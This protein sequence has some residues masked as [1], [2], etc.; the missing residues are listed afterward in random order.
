MPRL[1]RPLPSRRRAA[2]VIVGW[3]MLGGLAVGVAA[4]PR[5]AAKPA[6]VSPK[7]AAPVVL[8]SAVASVPAG[9]QSLPL[10]ALHPNF[11]DPA[12]EAMIVEGVKPAPLASLRGLIVPHHL[13]AA[14][15]IAR[16]YAA[17]PAGVTTVF[18]VGPNHRNEGGAQFTTAAA[19]WTT[20]AG[21]VSADEAQ[22]ARLA[23]D[24]G[25]ATS[26]EPFRDE[27]SVGVQ[28]Y[29]IRRFLPQAKIVP[30]I[31]DSYTTV[32][33][34]AAVG[35]WLA[36]NAPPHSL[37]VFSIDFSHY[38]V[39]AETRRHDAETRRAVEGRDLETISRFT[40]DNVD[41]PMSLVAALTFAK[42]AGLTTV[43]TANSNSNDFL[44]VKER[45]TT[46]H[47]LIEFTEK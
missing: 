22:A 10:L 11:F 31:L 26:V 17:A 34:A 5:G 40:N 8:T 39:E 24:L 33:Q 6:A 47:F 36:R 44:T 21:E 42:A 25:A 16:G 35:E 45:T 29:F 41:S 32:R 19:R 23:A 43:I 28:T 14:P 30:L 3:L 38:L 18:V 4:F 1:P 13:L 12:K 46:S 9:A 27:H 7:H 37:V 15:L 20:L 2:A